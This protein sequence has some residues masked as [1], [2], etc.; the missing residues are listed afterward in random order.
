MAEIM[1]R[2]PPSLQLVTFCGRRLGPGPYD[3][4]KTPFSLPAL[5]CP[6]A[7]FSVGNSSGE[8]DN[9]RLEPLKPAKKTRKTYGA[10]EMGI[11]S[12]LPHRLHAPKATAPCSRLILSAPCRAAQGFPK[13][14]KESWS[15]TTSGPLPA[16]LQELVT[17][18]TG[19]DSQLPQPR[20]FPAPR[21]RQRRQ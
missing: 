14:D 12:S 5:S 18:C 9:S 7:A 11:T 15:Q 1:F 21:R 2:P 10:R 8:K 6:P 16:N 4:S 20:S 17:K 19:Q 13:G 3:R